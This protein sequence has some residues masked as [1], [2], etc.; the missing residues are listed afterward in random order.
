MSY[1]W[2]TELQEDLGT[3]KVLHDESS[4]EKLS[5]DFYWYSPVLDIRLKEKKAD[6]IVVP[7]SEKEVVETLSSA[8]RHRIP[9]TVRGAG[10]G[11]YGQAIPLHGGIVLDMSELDQIMEMG[12]GYAR[13]QSGVKMGVLEKYAREKGQELRIYPSTF[14]KATIGG[15]ICGGSGGVGSITWG[16]LW[17]G[18]VLEAVIYTMEERPQRLVVNGEELSDYIHSYGTTGVMT[19]VVIPL[20]PKTEWMQIIFQFEDFGDA[21][22]F[23][24]ALGEDDLIPKR[25]ISPIEWPLPSFFNPLKKVLKRN[26]SVVFAEIGDGMLEKEL[27]RWKRRFW[28]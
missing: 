23:G 21:I 14:A 1:A 22:R 19:E 3:I 18:N 20:A 5:K 15:F 4:I 27:R 17:D 16:N 7:E 26:V 24:Q 11:N 25:L 12:D 28:R 10:T 2:K 9:V 8:F 6:V 13:V